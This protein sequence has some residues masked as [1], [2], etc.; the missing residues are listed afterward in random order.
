MGSQARRKDEGPGRL[1]ESRR[2][3]VASGPVGSQDK[4]E[5]SV[6]AHVNGPGL[7]RW[8]GETKEEASGLQAAWA[9]LHGNLS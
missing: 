3:Q 8:L 1:Q 5:R 7:V 6:E 2:R 9:F 4:E